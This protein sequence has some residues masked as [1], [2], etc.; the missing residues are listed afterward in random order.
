MDHLRKRFS[1]EL[2]PEPNTTDEELLLDGLSQPTIIP[3]NTAQPEVVTE[4]P[5]APANP[6]DNSSQ[7]TRHST[8]IRAPINRYSPSRYI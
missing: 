1:N 6:Q 7:P 3:L 5:V 4:E 8:R 2:E